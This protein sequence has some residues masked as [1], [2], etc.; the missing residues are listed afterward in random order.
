MLTGDSSILK[1]HLNTQNQR[2]RIFSRE[3]LAFLGF[4]NAEQLLPD[5]FV[6]LSCIDGNKIVFE[7]INPAPSDQTKATVKENV[8]AKEEPKDNKPEEPKQE[9]TTPIV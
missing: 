9:P 2:T 6:R 7:K 5:L 1:L 8:T 4:S 3:W